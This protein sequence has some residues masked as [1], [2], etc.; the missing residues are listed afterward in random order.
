ML[1]FTIDSHL[2]KD[3]NNFKYTFYAN[4]YN[5]PEEIDKKIIS[6][7]DCN[8]QEKNSYKC[9]VDK[10]DEKYIYIKEVEQIGTDINI[11][12]EYKEKLN[13]L[14]DVCDIEIYLEMNSIKE[15]VEKVDNTCI[16]ELLIQAYNKNNLI[17]L[18]NNSNIKL[19]EKD[20]CQ[21]NKVVDIFKGEDILKVVIDKPYLLTYY[22]IEKVNFNLKNI[23]GIKLSKK[24]NLLN[25]IIIT[26]RNSEKEGHA[27]TYLNQ[28]EK[29]IKDKKLNEGLQTLEKENL[30]AIKNDKIYLKDT[31]DIEEKLIN[32][33]LKRKEIKSSKIEGEKLESINKILDN[34]EYRLNKEQRKAIKESLQNNITIINGKAGT[35]KSTIIKYILLAIKEIEHKSKVEIISLAGK[36]VNV[37]S[38]KVDMD[39]IKPKTIHRFLKLKN[40]DYTQCIKIDKLDYLILDEMSMID[41][42]LLSAIVNA[43]PLY[44]K[45][46]FIGDLAQIQPIG[47]GIPIKDILNSQVFKKIELLINNRQGNNIIAK[48]SIKILECNNKLQFKKEEFELI[49]SKKKGLTILKNKI[50]HLIKSGYSFQDIMIISNNNYV[51][52]DIN[53]VIIEMISK[54]FRYKNQ[55]TIKD[56]VMQI[57]NNYSK[58]VFNGEIGQ[59]IAIDYFMN[60]TNIEVMFQDKVVNYQLEELNQLS[61]AYAITIHK[62]QGSQSKVVIFY[63]EKDD[64]KYLNRNTIYTAITRAEEKCIIIC[65]K[66]IFN[67]CICKLPQEKNSTILESLSKI[68]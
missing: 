43:I 64:E 56:K 16:S 4:K 50:E 33:L 25:K 32:N 17:K 30:I 68:A 28:V 46:I 49:D 26:L 12:N 63:V 60:K 61:F 67:N 9:T 7:I 34:S 44:T 51:V 18:F 65:D 14:I 11:L 52:S 19:K 23:K 53:K 54:E 59:I 66:E 27:F 57:K 55:F 5:F 24:N 36:A 45:I 31:Y 10:E 38:N 20:N 41:L 13:N 15:I 2:T 42:K 29:Y 8:F 22:F 21:F 37:I 62:S 48:N 6:N 40:D 35:G 1:K 3:D 58:K 39:R 47:I